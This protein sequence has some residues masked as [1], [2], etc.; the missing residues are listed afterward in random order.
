M[1]RNIIEIPTELIEAQH[2]VDLCFDT[3][4]VNGLAFLTT[5]SK[6]I[7]YCTAQYMPARTAEDYR[8]ALN[9]IFMIYQCGRFQITRVHYDCKFKP[10]INLLKHDHAGLQQNEYSAQEHVADAEQN[11]WTIKE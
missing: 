5:I 2:A 6:H 8:S 1:V 10:A 3:M 11:N 4:Y 9:K 7:H